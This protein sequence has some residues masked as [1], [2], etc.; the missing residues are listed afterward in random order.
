MLRRDSIDI[1]KVIESLES[2]FSMNEKKLAEY[3]VNNSQAI[4]DMTAKQLA[5]ESKTSPAAIVQK[6]WGSEDLKSFG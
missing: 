6:S 3:V 2:T 4:C 5:E 1:I